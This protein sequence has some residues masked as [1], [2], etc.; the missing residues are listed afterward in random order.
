MAAAV[1]LPMVLA[2]VIALD[3]IREGE[4][5]AALHGLQETV[6]A[7]ALIVD[8]EAQGAL[9]ALRAL[10]NSAYLRNGDLRGFYDQAAA[11]DQKPDI[12]TLLLDDQGQQLVNTLVPFGSPLPPPVARERV[13]QVLGSGKPLVTDLILGPVTRKLQI[14][15]YL[16]VRLPDGRS[17]VVAQ[18]FS[19]D[20][21]R[22]V[23]LYQ[24]IPADWIVAVIDRQG[25][26]IA[27]SHKSAEL[28]GSPARPELV[29]AAAKADRGLIRHS[30][31]ERIEVYDAFDHSELTGWTIAVAAPVELVDAPAQRA[32]Q[33]AMTGLALA[34][35]AAMLAAATFGQRFIR[36]IE[37]AGRA[38]VALGKGQQPVPQV[39]HL[40]ELDALN[41]A[42]VDA[43]ELLEAE[44]RSRQLAESET[45]AAPEPLTSCHADAE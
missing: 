22:Q 4:R 36:A 17:L 11:L 15:I 23:S 33:L 24:Q 40:D 44:R 39:T 10:G 3:K 28:V 9:S 1:L 18:G 13:A 5:K 27:R 45:S 2:S 19:V 38:A 41:R 16:P 20:R 30:T 31:V 32:L 37:G 21:W 7:T 12:W 42:L 14:T 25:K 26:F 6:R 8:R 34:V 29:A 35:L 43:G